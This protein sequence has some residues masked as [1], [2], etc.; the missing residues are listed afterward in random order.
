MIFRMTVIIRGSLI[1]IVCGKT[2]TL[3]PDG[4][5][6]SAALAMVTTDVETVVLG[7]EDIHEVRVNAVQ[8]AFAIWLLEQRIICACVGPVI[9]SLGLCLAFA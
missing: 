7:F 8:L 9:I 6:E 1:S 4:L 5:N 2:L 3:S